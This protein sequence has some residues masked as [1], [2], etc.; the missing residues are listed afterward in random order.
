MASI[1]GARLAPRQQPQLTL[2]QSRLVLRTHVRILAYMKLALLL[3]MACS[4]C[5]DRP[6]DSQ[7]SACGPRPTAPSI[8]ARQ[9]VQDGVS[10]VEISSTDWMKHE[11]W[12]SEMTDWSECVA[13]D[14]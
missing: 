9:V 11:S 3:V 12:V 6:V 5:T 4:A 10:H 2:T 13:A 8:F 14:G 1:G 7:P